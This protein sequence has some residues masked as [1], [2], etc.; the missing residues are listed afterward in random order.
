MHID[1]DVPIRMSDGN[2][3]KSNVY[4][5]ADAAGRPVGDQKT[6]TIVN[7]SPDTKLHPHDPGNPRSTRILA[8]TPFPSRSST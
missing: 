7:P 3:L 1:W 6:P 5:P 2:I 4:R 8:P